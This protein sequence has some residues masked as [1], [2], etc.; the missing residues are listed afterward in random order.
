MK[1]KKDNEKK[2]KRRIPITETMKRKIKKYKNEFYEDTCDGAVIN[3][4]NGFCG[5]GIL[6]KPQGHITSNINTVWVYQT[7]FDKK[8]KKIIELLNIVL[9]ENEAKDLKRCL[10][11]ALRKHP[12]YYVPL[13]GKERVRT[14]KPEQKLN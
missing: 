11:R 3:Y 2:M 8:G 14:R 5:V 6:E 1:N 9:T 4:L 12:R 13:K 7:G 10:S